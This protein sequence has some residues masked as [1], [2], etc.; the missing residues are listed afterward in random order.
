MRNYEKLQ[1][2][3]ILFQNEDIVTLSLEDVAPDASDD[4]A[5]DFEW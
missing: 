1:L 3:V 2:N 5:G 4:A